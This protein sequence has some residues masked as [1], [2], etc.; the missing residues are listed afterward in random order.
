MLFPMM[1]AYHGPDQNYALAHAVARRLL[2]DL[3]AKEEVLAG[4]I[5]AKKEQLRVLGDQIDAMK[6]A[7]EARLPILL[8]PVFKKL[9]LNPGSRNASIYDFHKTAQCMTIDLQDK[10]DHTTRRAEIP[11][12]EPMKSKCVE[13]VK[14]RA[15]YDALDKQRDV[16]HDSFSARTKKIEDALYD[17]MMQRQADAFIAKLPKKALANLKAIAKGE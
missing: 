5:E 17:L 15:E 13:W 1:D 4:Q 9:G 14:A 16:L 6:P 10:I 3:I 12:P 7:V 11:M 2:A 8:K